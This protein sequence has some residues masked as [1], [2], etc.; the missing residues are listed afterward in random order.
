M[1]TV[2][3][4]PVPLCSLIKTLVETFVCICCSFNTLTELPSH[5]LCLSFSYVSFQ[6]NHCYMLLIWIFLLHLA[7]RYAPL[8]SLYGP[9]TNLSLTLLVYTN[10][11]NHCL[12]TDIQLSGRSAERVVCDNSSTFVLCNWTQEL[13]SLKRCLHLT[14]ERRESFN[15]TFASLCLTM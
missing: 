2:F 9:H 11:L 7:A 8:I 1:S 6:C 5:I 10:I 15:I 12:S 14:E 3:L 4:C 13:P